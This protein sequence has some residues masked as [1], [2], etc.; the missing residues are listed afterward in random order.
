M[1]NLHN[2]DENENSAEIGYW[3]AKDCWGNNYATEAVSALLNYCFK[4]L[5]LSVVYGMCHNKNKAS[6]R[7]MEKCGMKYLKSESI[8]FGKEEGPAEIYI[9]T[10]LNK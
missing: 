5:K 1:I 3:I 7:V 6:V 8:S 2:I 10:I 9:F 4:N